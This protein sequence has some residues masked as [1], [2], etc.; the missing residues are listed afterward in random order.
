MNADR[1][2]RITNI[3]TGALDEVVLFDPQD[4]ANEVLLA[5]DANIEL[6]VDLFLALA[7]F[8]VTEKR[9]ILRV[10]LQGQSVREATK[11]MKRTSR[12]Y[13]KWLSS[14]VLPYLR[15]QLAAYKAELRT[16]LYT[17]TVVPA[18]AEETA[19]FSCKCKSCP[20][21]TSAKTTEQAFIKLKKHIRD[22]HPAH[23]SAVAKF[24][25]EKDYNIRLAELSVKDEVIADDSL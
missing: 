14:E 11:T 10:L 3:S 13:E 18:P 9:I 8:S 24:V 25:H 23:A 5:F 4:E 7:K 17:P 12:Y 20:E 19:T 16:V 6:K 21:T 2:N 1:P 15:K 22:A